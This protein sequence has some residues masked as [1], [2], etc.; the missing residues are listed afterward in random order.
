MSFQMFRFMRNQLYS[1]FMFD[2]ICT[3]LV[4]TYI[5]IGIFEVI[6]FDLCLPFLLYLCYF[7]DIMTKVIKGRGPTPVIAVIMYRQLY[8]ST[9]TCFILL[10]I[11]NGE[12]GEY[13]GK[14]K[15]TNSFLFDSLNA[16]SSISH[17]FWWRINPR[18]EL[19]QSM[20]SLHCSQGWNQHH[21]PALKVPQLTY[22]HEILGW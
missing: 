4:S 20:Y 3:F 17:A 5:Y 12:Y 21:C 16:L 13:V 2:C 15:N 11:L 7:Q 10:L 1:L 9:S 19:G 22:L 14:G 8:Q 6:R 18:Y